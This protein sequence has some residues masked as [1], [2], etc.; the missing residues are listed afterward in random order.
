MDLAGGRPHTMPGLLPTEIK[1]VR[2]PTENRRWTA[3]LALTD[4]GVDNGVSAAEGHV[5][6]VAFADQTLTSVGNHDYPPFVSPPPPTQ[7]RL[8]R[9]L[10]ASGRRL[11]PVRSA[12]RLAV[13]VRRG[14]VLL[15]L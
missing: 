6:L 7:R 13:A 2:L 14:M 4:E 15:L 9:L 1:Y 11:P 3:D 5:R 8:I 10:A 12:R